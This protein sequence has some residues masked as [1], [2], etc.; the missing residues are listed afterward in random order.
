MDST[1]PPAQPPAS[2]VSSECSFVDEALHVVSQ[3]VIYNELVHSEVE[4]YGK[5]GKLENASHFPTTPTAD[6]GFNLL[7]LHISRGLKPRSF[8]RPHSA[9]LKP[10]PFKTTMVEFWGIPPFRQKEGERMGHPL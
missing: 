1:L 5:D 6:T 2:T 7:T 3:D 9:R 10:C 4:G 8:W